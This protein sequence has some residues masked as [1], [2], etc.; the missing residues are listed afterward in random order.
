[1]I[2]EQEKKLKDLD[3]DKRKAELEVEKFK[4]KSTDGVIYATVTGVVKNLQDKDD[5]PND[6]TPF[7]EVTGSEGLYVTGGVS[8]L[9]L[10]QVKPGQTI[11]VSSW[12]SGVSCEAR[13]PRLRTIRR[14]RFLLTARAIR[15]C[16]IIRLSLT[17][18][19]PPVCATGNMWI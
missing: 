6:G 10:D 18:K 2:A 16:P 5:L 14:R 15:M 9:L 8:E 11:N 17:S 1:M 7:M 4:A 13:S 19:I 3:L 12:E